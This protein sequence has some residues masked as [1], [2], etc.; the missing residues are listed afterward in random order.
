MTRQDNK[1]EDTYLGLTDGTFKARFN[2]HTSSFRNDKYIHATRLSDHIWTLKDNGVNFDIHWSIIC[3]AK[4]YSP[5]TNRCN[6]CLREKFFIIY[7]PQM[8]SLKKRNELPS[9]CKHGTKYLLCIA[10]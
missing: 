6:L 9:T 3:R 7:R 8:S 5:A 10:T 2:N 4:S 1:K